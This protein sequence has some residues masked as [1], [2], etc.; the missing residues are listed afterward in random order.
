M[1]GQPVN[2]QPDNSPATTDPLADLRLVH[3]PGS[4]RAEIADVEPSDSALS[5]DVTVEATVVLR[6]RAAVPDSA[7]SGPGISSAELAEKYGA[8]PADVQAVSQRFEALGLQIVSVDAA[9][10]RVRVRGPIGVMERV[11]GTSLSPVQR[12]NAT[13]TARA[14]R[15]RSR[16]PVDPG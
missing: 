16:R 3:L 10:R 13:G 11:F 2:G 8:D 1:P 5:P 9:S 14:H 6:R 12:T 4:E 15:V 7:L